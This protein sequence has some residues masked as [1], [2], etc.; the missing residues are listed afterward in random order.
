MKTLTPKT[1]D[2]TLVTDPVESAKT[3][4]L[5]YVTDDSPGICR[6]RRGKGFSYIGVDGK[7]LTDKSEIKRIDSLVIPPAWNDVWICPIANGHLQATGRDAKG[8]KQY[9]YHPHWCTVRSQ[10][11]FNRMIPFSAA[12]PV[13]REQ[14]NRDLAHKGLPR[15]KVLATAV[16]LLETTHIRIGNAEYAQ[17]NKTFGLTTLR[18]RHVDV[19]STTIHFHF[20]G[21]SGVKHDIELRDRK[22]ARII[23]RCQ[24]IPGYELF[25]YVDNEG[26]R[27]S[28]SSEDVNNYL[29]EIT[30]E[31]FTAK[32]FRTW[33][34]TVLAAR[35]LKQMPPFES[36]TQA[37]KNVAQAIKAVA[38]ELGNKPATSRKYY[39][40]PAIIDAYLEGTLGEM[41]EEYSNSTSDDSPYNLSSE[42]RAVVAI[43]ERS[44]TD[45]EK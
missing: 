34:G 31:D 14:I 1:C 2:L 11:K 44:L 35:E 24:D 15:E 36:Q 32:D 10:T 39:V 25:Q 30:G 40:H 38:K 45:L 12:L 28:I 3:A 27:H 43:L 18:N 6:Q 5:R 26:Q 21:K 16:R 7:R 19:T 22:L 29:R 13:I 42:E 8:R 37:K 41:L 4:G 23:K 9:R 33:A 20:K 17:E